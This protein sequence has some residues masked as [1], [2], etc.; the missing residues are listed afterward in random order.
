MCK[1]GDNVMF[2]MNYFSA[3]Q[4]QDPDMREGTIIEVMDNGM[5]RVEHRNH[6]FRMS[7]RYYSDVPDVCEM[8]M[9]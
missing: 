7:K 4:T 9:L 8:A 1:I 2:D 6:T 5:L 3:E